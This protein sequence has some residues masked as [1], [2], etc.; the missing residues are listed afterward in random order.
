[1]VAVLVAGAHAGCASINYGLAPIPPSDPSPAS[2]CYYRGALTL[3]PG[4]ASTQIVDDS[5][6]RMTYGPGG[7]MMSQVGPQ[8]MHSTGA[9]GY[10]FFLGDLRLSPRDG[11]ARLDD[12]RLVTRYDRDLDRFSSGRNH[13]WARPLWI[14][15]LAG[16]MAL[17]GVGVAQVLS[18]KTDLTTG[19]TDYGSAIPLLAG[20]IGG[21]LASIPFVA[22]DLLNR[23]AEAQLDA[24]EALLV[25]DKDMGSSVDAAVQRHNAQV[26]ATCGYAH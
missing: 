16:S 19:K 12:P 7:P 21:L 1:M 9:S 4:T 17:I 18:A 22:L 3:V 14:T 6:M 8:V 2:R 23:D 5:G 25:P 26:A 10:S 15:L 20:S 24:R 11:L 13:V